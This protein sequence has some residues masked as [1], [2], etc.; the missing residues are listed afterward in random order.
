[1]RRKEPRSKV[2][3][4]PIL[5]YALLAM[6]VFSSCAVPEKRPVSTMEEVL[7]EK[8]FDLIPKSEENLYSLQISTELEKD[9]VLIDDEYV[10][11]YIEELGQRLVSRT[12]YRYFVEDYEWAF[13]IIETPEINAF[14]TLGGKIY[15]SRG[16]IEATERESELAGVLAFEMGHVMARSVHQHISQDAVKQS[17][18]LPGEMIQGHEGM[19]SLNQVLES[20]GGAYRYFSNLEYYPEEIEK[21]DKFA[22]HN[23]YDA[24]FN[25]RSFI[26]FMYRLLESERQEVFPLWVQRNPWSLEREDHLLALLKLFPPVAFREESFNFESFKIQL[27]SLTPPLSEIEEEPAFPEYAEVL[28]I[29]VLGNVDW[30]DTGL[31]VDI[32]QQIYFR[33]SGGISLQKGN[34]LAYCGPDGYNLKTMQQPIPD[35]K[36]GSLIGK[37]V[38][39]ISIE[40]DEETEEEIRNEIEKYFYIGSENRVKMEIDGRLFLGINEN[41]VGDNSGEFQVTIFIEKSIEE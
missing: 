36:I 15:V 5:L 41:I 24:G 3:C 22:L 28:T 31:D 21:A 16:L 23:S 30:T 7:P 32:D 39:L 38:K 9:V 34:P 4:F 13:K 20:E 12:P 14:A 11:R 17:L 8:S 40:I 19:E 29:N 37:V 35:E 25:P 2:R 18:V 1:M 6:V 27:Q 10:V 33:A 26:I